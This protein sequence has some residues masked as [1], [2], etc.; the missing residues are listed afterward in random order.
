[1]CVCDSGEDLPVKPHKKWVHMN[2]LEAEKLEWMKD[3]P[4][5]RRKGTK[6]VGKQLKNKTCSVSATPF[7]FF[8]KSFLYPSLSEE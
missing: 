8:N 2:V 1:M 5:P 6:K 3:L 7:N 4:T